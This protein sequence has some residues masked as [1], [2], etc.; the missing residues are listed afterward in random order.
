MKLD[1]G[2]SSAQLSSE[3]KKAWGYD[4]ALVYSVTVGKEGLQTSLNVQNK[5]SKSFDFQTLLH[6]YFKIDVSE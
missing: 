3:A 1:F 4:F 5:G 6:S 2:L